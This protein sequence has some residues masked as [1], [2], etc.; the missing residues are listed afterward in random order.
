M[1]S[2]FL[3]LWVFLALG[4][5]CFGG[6]AILEKKKAWKEDLLQGKRSPFKGAMDH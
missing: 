6:Q 2:V 5:V 1:V 4:G 3:R